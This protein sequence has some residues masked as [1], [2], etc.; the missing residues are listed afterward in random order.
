MQKLQVAILEQNSMTVMHQYWGGSHD[1]ILGLL[2]WIH[3]IPLFSM[4]R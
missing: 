2:L 4:Q 3:E 1:L